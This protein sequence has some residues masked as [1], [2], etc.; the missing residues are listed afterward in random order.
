MSRTKDA[1]KEPKMKKETI[2]ERTKR[3][4]KFNGIPENLIDEH[5]KVCD[6]LTEEITLM[7]LGASMI[8]LF[9]LKPLPDYP[10]RYKTTWGSKTAQGIGA[11]VQR[12][13]E[14]L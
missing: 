8:A 6:R 1:M 11:S 2:H 10:D 12:I 7:R 5:K 3:A 9:D 13:I 4:A 14:E